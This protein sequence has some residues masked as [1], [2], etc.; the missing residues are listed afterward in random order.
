[1]CFVNFW[2]CSEVK[3]S[4]SCHCGTINIS[5]CQIETLVSYSKST[6]VNVNMTFPSSNFEGNC[7]TYVFC[8]SFWHYWELKIDCW[9]L[10]NILCEKILNP[11]VCVEVRILVEKWK[12][13]RTSH[14]PEIIITNMQIGNDFL[15][16]KYPFN[17]KEKIFKFWLFYWN[18]CKRL[19][20]MCSPRNANTILHTL[21]PNWQ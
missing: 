10:R 8:K 3:W 6:N 20:F 9:T 15:V 5:N 19:S 4:Q 17:C 21:K 14:F 11:F 12:V 1:M 7:S 13:M 16:F 18:L 2:L